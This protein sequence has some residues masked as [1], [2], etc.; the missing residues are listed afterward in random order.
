MILPNFNWY[1]IVIFF[2]F[3]FFCFANTCYMTR[4]K[5]AV[6]KFYIIRIISTHARIDNLSDVISHSFSERIYSSKSHVFQSNYVHVL[7]YYTI[8]FNTS[9]FRNVSRVVL[10]KVQALPSLR[11]FSA[12]DCIFLFSHLYKCI[13]VRCW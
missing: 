4:V 2:S 13:I 12:I 1:L 3:F 11:L 6:S 10:A 8:V 7:Y 9:C 5:V